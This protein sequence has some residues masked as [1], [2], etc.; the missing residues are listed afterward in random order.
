MAY[1]VR[2]VRLFSGWPDDDASEGGLRRIH[3]LCGLTLGG[4]DQANAVEFERQCFGQCTQPLDHLRLITVGGQRI[5]LEQEPI[6][7]S[8]IGQSVG[9]CSRKL[10]K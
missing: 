3:H 10:P 4:E 8:G 5:Q 9:S 2:S 7:R 6:D 1:V